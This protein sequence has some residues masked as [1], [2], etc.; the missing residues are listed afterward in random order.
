[1]ESK[2]GTCG[3]DIADDETQCPACGHINKHPNPGE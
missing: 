3:A 1:M 2:C